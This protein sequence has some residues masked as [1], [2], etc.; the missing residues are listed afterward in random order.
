MN[1]TRVS[2]KFSDLKDDI[3]PL[4]DNQGLAFSSWNKEDTDVLVLSG[5]AG[6]GK[7]FLGMYLGLTTMAKNDLYNNIVIVRSA[8]PTKNIGFLPGTEEEKNAVYESPYKGIINQIVKH[9]SKAKFGGDVWGKLKEQGTVQ[10]ES[11]SFLRG[12]T[13]DNTIVIVDEMQNCTMHELDTVM[14]RIGKD[15]KIIFCGDYYQSDLS[16]DSDKKGILEFL[17]ILKYM[18]K[19]DVVEFTWE[20]CVRS[21]IVRDYLMTKE[22]IA[23]GKMK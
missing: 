20:D 4:T 7:T 8:E 17:N 14:T 1:N 13:W 16:K 18:K 23:K 3:K 21:G 19:S 12:I 2:F 11:T 22:L 5:A 10:F 15:S 6:A 9:S